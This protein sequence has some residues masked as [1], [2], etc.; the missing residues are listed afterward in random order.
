[1]NDVEDDDND[2]DHYGDHSVDGDDYDNTNGDLNDVED[3]HNVY[4]Y[5][6]DHSDDD[7]DYDNTNGD[8]NDGQYPLLV[9]SV[10]C[11]QMV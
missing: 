10:C 2:Y 7:D 6:G 8:L 3:D 9:P 1:M 5:N 11:P 4:E